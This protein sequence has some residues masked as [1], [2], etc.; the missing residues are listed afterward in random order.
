MCEIN[1]GGKGGFMRPRYD[2][3]QDAAKAWNTRATQPVDVEKL[4]A[5]PLN[6]DNSVHTRIYIRG[7]NEAIDRLAANYDFVPKKASG[8]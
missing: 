4:K 5:K 6:D 7:Y 2:T 8:G 3:E 1:N